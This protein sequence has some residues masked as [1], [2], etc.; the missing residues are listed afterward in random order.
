MDIRSVPASIHPSMHHCHIRVL[1]D[2]GSLGDL[3][4]RGDVR[5]RCVLGDFVSLAI[6]GVSSV[7]E[8]RGPRERVSMKFDEQEP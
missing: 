6:L 1:R 2:L 4:S 3:G 5:T 8:A 7:V